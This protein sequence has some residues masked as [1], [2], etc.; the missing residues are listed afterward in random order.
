MLKM[1]PFITFLLYCMFVGFAVYYLTKDKLDEKSRYILIGIL[2]LPYIFMDQMSNFTNVT[3]DL[4]GN[5]QEQESSKYQIS[6][7][8]TYSNLMPPKI[9]LSKFEKVEN[10]KAVEEIKNK[11]K[12]SSK[13]MFTLE[14]V[15]NLLNNAKNIKNK[16][17]IENYGSMYNEDVQ[18]NY[19][20]DAGFTSQELKPL[21][22]NGNGFTNSWDHDYILLNTD[23]WAPALKPPPV[24]KTEK[25]CPVC[26]NLTSGYPL[27]LRDFDSTRKI[28]PPIQVDTP[29]MN[30]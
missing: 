6:R 15:Q 30:A 10:I 12:D 24:C 29:S 16:P 11:Q 25:K 20:D 13:N 1:S 22:Q 5:E 26:P 3:S 2:I 14:E 4:S 27:M 9:E 19:N 28:T 17:I 7:P 8:E 21:G 18:T 23:K